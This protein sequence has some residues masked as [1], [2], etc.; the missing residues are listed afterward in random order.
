VWP[1]SCK[2]KQTF[3]FP[4]CFWSWCS[5]TMIETLTKLTLCIA[6]LHFWEKEAIVICVEVWLKDQI[7]K[8]TTECR[9]YYFYASIFS[10]HFLL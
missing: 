8:E 1:E 10:I 3:F 5:I 7:V 6:N 4:S 9:K 2:L